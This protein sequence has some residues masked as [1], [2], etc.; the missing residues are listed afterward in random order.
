MNQRKRQP[1][2]RGFVHYLDYKL[3]VTTLRI[4]VKLF[5]K[6][7]KVLPPVDTKLVIQLVCILCDSFGFYTHFLCNLSA[8]LPPHDAIGQ[9]IFAAS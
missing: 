5:G 4:A 1:S 9:L 2:G 6:P 7:K 3:Q 8:A